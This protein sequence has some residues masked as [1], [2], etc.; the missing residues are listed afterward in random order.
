MENKFNFFYKNLCNKDW[1]L[2][3]FVHDVIKKYNLPKSDEFIQLSAMMYEKRTIQSRI[4]FSANDIP[5]KQENIIF[6][7]GNDGDKKPIEFKNEYLRTVRKLLELT[8]ENYGLWVKMPENVI[9]GSV[10]VSDI[11]GVLCITFDKHLVWGLMNGNEKILEYREG[12]YSIPVIQPEMER[13]AQLEELSRLND[14]VG[15]DKIDNIKNVVQKIVPLCTHGSSI[16]FMSNNGETEGIAAEVKR[17]ASHNKA[18]QVKQFPLVQLIDEGKNVI[19]E[20]AEMDR[21]RGITSIDGA[22]FCDLDC[23]CWA[24]GVIVDGETIIDGDYGRGARFNTITNY[25]AGYKIKNPDN[26]CFA[27]IIS[28][29]GMINVVPTKEGEE[30]IEELKNEEQSEKLQERKT[31]SAEI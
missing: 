22:I 14:T 6:E 9:Q 30:K 25:I 28:E 21:I 8:G 16:V 18:Y 29:D 12:F 17:L 15:P 5:N 11:E 1:L 23:L 10:R 27:V 24:V 20:N 19:D 7:K 26:V 13:N 3:E 31:D 2:R 4:Y